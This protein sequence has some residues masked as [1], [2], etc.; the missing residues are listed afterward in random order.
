MAGA[1]KSG[2]KILLSILLL[3]LV[4]LATIYWF[5]YIGLI[6]I[7]RS[8]FRVSKKI[9]LISYAKEIESS[10]KRFVA[11]FKL[12][13]ERFISIFQVLLVWTTRELPECRRAYYEC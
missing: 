9:P 10:Y 7:Q 13:S 3:I 6:N 11:V 8:L 12:L 5:N 1:E 4:L 2:I